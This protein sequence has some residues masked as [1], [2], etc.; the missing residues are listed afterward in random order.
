MP[1]KVRVKTVK[2]NKCNLT[3]EPEYHYQSIMTEASFCTTKRCALAKMD[4][5]FLEPYA[6]EQRDFFINPID[7]NDPEI[8]KPSRGCC[9]SNESKP[10]RE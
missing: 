2:C 3:W 8:E 6:T 10:C 1:V 7:G 9:A 5:A 4:L